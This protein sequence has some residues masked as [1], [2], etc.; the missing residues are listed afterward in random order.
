MASLGSRR[1]LQ[2]TLPEFVVR[3]LEHSDCD[4][5]GSLRRL[6]DE[7]NEEVAHGAWQRSERVVGGGQNKWPGQNQV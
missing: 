7:L 2:V 1:S 5:R 3:A 4:I 6:A